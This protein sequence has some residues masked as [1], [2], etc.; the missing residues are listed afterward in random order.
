MPYRQEAELVLAAWREVERQLDT[1]P[2]AS[3]DAELLR[4]EAARLRDRYQALVGA[5]RSSQT[6]EPPPVPNAP[7]RMV[8]T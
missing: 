8:G 6:P 1:T 2:E 7:E 4:A 5:A 3:S